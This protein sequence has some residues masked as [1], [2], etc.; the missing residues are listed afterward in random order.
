MIKPTRVCFIANKNGCNVFPFPFKSINNL[1]YRSP[2]PLISLILSLLCWLSLTAQV[3]AVSRLECLG[4]AAAE[5]LVPGTGYLFTKQWD[6]AATLGGVRWMALSKVQ[7]AYSS[8]YYQ[9]DPEDIYFVTEADQSVSGKDEIRIVLNKETWEGNYFANIYGNLLLITW[10]DFYQNSCEPNTDT[11]QLMLAP[12][13]F[14]HFYDKWYFWAPLILAASNFSY[15]SDDAIVEY[16]LKRGLNRSDLR[17]QSFGEYYLVGVGEE[18]F[19]RGL[20]Q[21]H[22]FNRLQ[23][24]FGI[25]PFWSRHLSVAGASAIFAAAH[26]G[27]GFTANPGSAFL[28]GLYEGYVYHNSLDEFDLITAIAIH[29]WWDILVTYAVLNNAEFNESQADVQIPLFQIG[30]K[31]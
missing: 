12:F 15:Y 21:N 24:S 31:Y 26:N 19:F 18:M 23:E 9:E 27:A 29:S 25:S 6:K 22:L 14:D 8:G 1:S 20:V 4:A 5:Y 2:F 10:A 17:S 7:A 13:R 28:F 16:N 30:F 3:T 11:Y